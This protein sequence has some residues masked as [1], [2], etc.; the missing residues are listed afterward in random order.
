MPFEVS[1]PRGLYLMKLAREP[2]RLADGLVFT[3]SIERR[4]G[5]EKVAFRCRIAA[6]L[7]GESFDGNSDALVGR[8]G[9]WLER[10]FEQTR[11]AALRSIRGERKLAEIAF[12]ESNRGPF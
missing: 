8:L 5:L 4:D 1:T 2:E 10:E 12:D 9:A 11:E 7:L 3:L 6:G